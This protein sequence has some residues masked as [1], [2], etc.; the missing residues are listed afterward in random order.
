MPEIA[1]NKPPSFCGN[2]PSNPF[3]N[4]S[5]EAPDED[6]FI[7]RDWGPQTPDQPPL[8]SEWQQSSCLGICYST[9]SQ[10]DA[11][12]CA[13]RVAVLCNQA[14]WTWKPL[15]GVCPDG[16]VFNPS[17]GFCEVPVYCNTPQTCFSEC[18]DGSPFAFTQTFPAF[19][20]YNNQAIANAM[21][22]SFACT[23][24]S[25]RRVCLSDL[26]P[27]EC[28]MDSPYEASILFSG[29]APATL[30]IVSGMLPPGIVANQAN[31]TSPLVLSGTP[32]AD[33]DFTFTVRAQ[34]DALDFMEKTYTL[35]I[36]TILNSVLT[37]APIDQ[38]Y[39]FSLT[40][41]GTTTGP[42]QWSLISGTLPDGI[43]LNFSTGE[44]FGTPTSDGTYTFSI[45]FSDDYVTLCAKDLTLT[46]SDD[47]IFEE[48][49]WVEQFVVQDGG[50]A[51]GTF[52]A[53]NF[54]ASAESTGSWFQPGG[55]I[56]YAGT[57]LYT[58]DAINC[59]IE[60]TAF[61]SSSS[62]VPQ[63]Q[64]S[65]IITSDADGTLISQV[66][67]S[68]GVF[69]FV[70]PASVGAT[71]TVTVEALASTGTEFFPASQTISATG[72]ITGPV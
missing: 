31:N 46:V 72:F 51:S 23:E 64:F 16:T 44:I 54:T 60:I 14:N 56:N 40:I 30:T 57:L 41:G 63:P 48:L 3:S 6:V 22:L 13:S 71:I 33:G 62:G 37:D 21:A 4:L 5:A 66:V 42:V 12:L 36:V 7:G 17:T 52:L 20:G 67:V 65:V 55:N 11:N 32:T 29:A 53:E 19:C 58:G 35:S 28:C 26:I 1:C 39:S 24:A 59:E 15:L 70:I 50:T 47:N 2:D 18:P 8:G 69:P 61:S 9:V 10:A 38:P 43:F 27:P 34:T 45:G 49:I 68:T 25:K